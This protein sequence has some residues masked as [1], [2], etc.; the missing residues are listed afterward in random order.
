[1]SEESERFSEIKYIC[2]ELNNN[3]RHYSSLRFTQLN[4]YIAIVA[5][6]VSVSFGLVEIKTPTPFDIRFWSKIGGLMFTL[7]FFW[8]EILC[9][10]NLKHIYQIAK[11]ELPNKYLGLTQR[12]GHP[13]LRAQYATWGLYIALIVFWLVT[14]VKDLQRG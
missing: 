5:G 13:A 4:I 10:L 9:H 11:E 12:K 1:M 8:V 14:I 6:L 7:V 2:T 3:R